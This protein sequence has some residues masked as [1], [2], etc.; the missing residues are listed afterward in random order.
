MC[1]LVRFLLV[2][3]V[4]VFQGEAKIATDRLAT[5]FLAER[6]GLV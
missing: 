3:E 2:L 5:I 6:V 4:R 1:L